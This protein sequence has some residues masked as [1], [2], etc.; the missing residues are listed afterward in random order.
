MI[1]AAHRKTRLIASENPALN[2]CAS[3]AGS[4]PMNEVSFSAPDPLLASCRISCACA[5]YA[6]WYAGDALAFSIALTIF[7]LTVL[8]RMDRNTAAPSVPPIDR[9]NVTDEV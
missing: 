3:T 8:N 5:A 1:P 6:C 2:G 4:R 7:E 9:K